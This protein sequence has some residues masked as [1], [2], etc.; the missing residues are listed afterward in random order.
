MA[1]SATSTAALAQAA[2]IYEATFH[3]PP[4]AAR[5]PG[6]PRRPSAGSMRT[7]VLNVRTST[8][9]PFLTRD[10]LCG[11][12]GLDPDKVRVFCERVGGGFGGKQE[13]L[14]E[15]LRRARGAATGRPVQL[16]VHPRGAVHRDHRAASDAGPRQGRRRRRRHAHR[17]RSSTCC[18]TPAPT[19]T[20]RPGVMF[21]GCGESITSTAART[22]GSTPRPSTP[23][24]CRRAR[25]AATG[26]AR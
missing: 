25:S 20:T 15:D 26:S 1:T 11:L 4:R 9:V 23:T 2:V 22:R 6:D 3:D 19:A 21:H 7:G 12:F 10:E 16:R 17:A 13:M 14:I 24:P 8:Q 5:A 18:P